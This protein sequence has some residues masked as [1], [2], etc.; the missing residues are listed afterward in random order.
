MRPACVDGKEIRLATG[1]GSEGDKPGATAS[2]EYDRMTVQR[3]RKTFPRARWDD[4]RNVWF[5]PGTTASRR[6]RRWLDLEASARD[7]YADAKGRDAF[8]FEPIVSKYLEPGDDLVIRTPYSR[9]VVAE[10]QNVPFAAWDDARRA[11]R[12]PYRSLDD[13]RS[14]W[15]AIEAAASRNEPEEK[16]RRLLEAKRTGELEASRLRAAER[17]RR[18]Y[19]LPADDLPPPE[20]PVTTGQ[21]GVIAFTEVTGELADPEAVGQLYDQGP[22]VHPDLVWGTWRVPSFGEL[23]GT[24]PSKPPDASQRERGWWL[25]TKEELVAAR[26][27]ARSREKRKARTTT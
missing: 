18:R 26:K 7:I 22:R 25:P 27:A 14:R 11:W 3:F 5:V 2:F 4:L 21:Y 10:L 19:P 15:P 9:T 6:I 20:R 23:V 17:R 24:W 8:A 13:L 1:A 12:V 16:R